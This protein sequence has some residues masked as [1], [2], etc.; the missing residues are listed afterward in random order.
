MTVAPALKPIAAGR[1]SACPL[2]DD[3]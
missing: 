3:A 1:L 2:N